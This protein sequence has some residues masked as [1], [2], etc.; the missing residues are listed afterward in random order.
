MNEKGTEYKR[1]KKR[2]CLVT[3]YLSKFI[4]MKNSFIKNYEAFEVKVCIGHVYN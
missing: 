2:T 4:S 1:N 3:F